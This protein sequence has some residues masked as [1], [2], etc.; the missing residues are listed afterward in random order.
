MTQGKRVTN[1]ATGRA[2]HSRRLNSPSRP[3]AT[4]LEKTLPHDDKAEIAF[5]C[6]AITYPDRVLPEMLNMPVEA[7]YRLEAQSLWRIVRKLHAAGSVIDLATINAAITDPREAAELP[8]FL[9]DVLTSQSG[10]P[11]A[12]A[13][14]AAVILDAHRRRQLIELAH[15]VT[16]AANDKGTDIAHMEREI[17]RQLN[18][19]APARQAIK[20]VSAAELLAT[21][22]PYATDIVTGVLPHRAKLILSAPAKLGKTRFTLGL[23]LAIATGKAAMG[24]RVTNPARVLYL[25]AEVSARA[26]QDRLCK[27]LTSFDADEAAL[28]ERLLL[29]NAPGLKL[30]NP[31][32]VAAIRQAIEL[33]KPD[34]LAIDPLYK[35]HT[36]DESSVQDMTRFFDPLD[37]L[38]ADYGCSV[39]LVHHHGKGSG[40][41]LATP[42]HRNRGSSTIADWADSLLTLT[43]ED[44][45]AG[46]VKLAFTLRNAEE[47]EPMAFER[48]PET[49]WF[50]LLPDYQFTGKV[51]ATKITEQAVADTIGSGRQIAYT[52]LVE[53]LRKAF[54]VSDGTA[55]TAIRRATEA[56]T[57]RKT[58][59][60]LYEQA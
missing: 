27:M 1:S 17:V 12:A 11:S 36:G 8:A 42:A 18:A 45:E 6:A 32:H 29:H 48:N 28:R 56:G 10:L 40:D 15:R 31:A 60:G 26:L 2:N 49:L 5:L 13:D 41:G 24:F 30:T 34:V 50:D 35:F 9:S 16:E 37:A 53:A 7:F 54:T 14:Y 44:A 25:Q 23:C 52:R 55:R 58:E 39:L 57:I 59:G 21:N 22:F 38:I 20:I 43:F 4:L 19:T 3:V 47:P 33:Y 51:S 46:I